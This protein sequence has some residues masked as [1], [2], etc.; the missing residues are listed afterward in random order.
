MAFIPTGIRTRHLS[1]EY[2][3]LYLRSNSSTELSF[4]TRAFS[5]A[6]RKK[7]KRSTEFLWTWAIILDIDYYNHFDRDPVWLRF[8]RCGGNC[9]LLLKMSLQTFTAGLLTIK[10]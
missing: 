5:N 9:R 3:D 7:F 6:S 10:V 8:R 2:L 1:N 4:S